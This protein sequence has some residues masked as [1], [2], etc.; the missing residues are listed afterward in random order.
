MFCYVVFLLLLCDY[1]VLTVS[2]AFSTYHPAVTRLRWFIII[3]LFITT[4]FENYE[5]V[6]PGHLR[7]PRRAAAGV[8]CLAVG[9][10]RRQRRPSAFRDRP[11]GG[12]DDFLFV[13]S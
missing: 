10:R 5:F 11:R 1:I 3:N 7:P 13:I 2:M 6:I 9:R 4:V 12:G 8:R